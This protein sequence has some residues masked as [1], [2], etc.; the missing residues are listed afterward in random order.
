MAA[1][2]VSK[3][4]AQ[5]TTTIVVANIAVVVAKVKA[6]VP[7]TIVAANAAI[8]KAIVDVIIAKR[9]QHKLQLQF[10]KMQIV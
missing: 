10:L 7:A 1:I 9:L 2:V 6:Q 5:V 4:K 3:V 8:M